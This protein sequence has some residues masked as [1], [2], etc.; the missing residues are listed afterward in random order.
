MGLLGDRPD[1]TGC[2]NVNV[3]KMEMATLHMVLTCHGGSHNIC[4]KGKS[5]KCSGEGEICVSNK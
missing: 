1:P 2:G 4:K 5:E 3:V